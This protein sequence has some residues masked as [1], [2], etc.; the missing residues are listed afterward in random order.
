MTPSAK[1]SSDTWRRLARAHLLGVRLGEETLTDLLV[2]E[3]LHFQKSNAFRIYHPTRRE[4]SWCGADLLVWI[5][6]RNGLSRF[7]A[8]QAK[9]IYPNGH[10]K[11]LNH[12]VSPGV[13]QIDLLDAFAHQYRALPLYLLYNHFDSRNPNSY[14]HCCKSFDIEQLG[15]TLVPSWKIDRAIKRWGQRTFTAVHAKA[16]SRPW[17]CV[18]DCD[19]PER[20]LMALATD[21]ERELPTQVPDPDDARADAPGPYPELLRIDLPDSLLEMV[22]PLPTV[23]LDDQLRRQV[24]EHSKHAAGG[25]LRSEHQLLYPRKLLIVDYADT[26]DEGED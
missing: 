16:P 6:R 19:H 24:D 8:I 23:A 15:C 9:K 7:L 13:R 10:Y 20:Q 18:F 12:H 2:L 25:K 21:P 4:E 22:K 1:I 5:R 17:R 14:W 11:A 26:V 3:M